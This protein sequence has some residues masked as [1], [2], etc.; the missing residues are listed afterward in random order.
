M[1]N[2]R[3]LSSK[4]RLCRQQFLTA[5]KWQEVIQKCRQHYGKRR[6]LSL[7][8]LRAISSFLTVKTSTADM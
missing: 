1:T 6:N 2:F 8:A 4:L 5:R 3:L 7:R